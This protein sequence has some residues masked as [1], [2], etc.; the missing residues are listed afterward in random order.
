MRN[1]ASGGG[2]IA[3]SQ[4]KGLV[5]GDP[6][7]DT[8]FKGQLVVQDSAFLGNTATAAGGA[9]EIS[10]VT[11]PARGEAIFDN[12]RVEER[13]GANST[14]YAIGASSVVLLRGRDSGYKWETQSWGQDT[15]LKEIE[16]KKHEDACIACDVFAEGADCKAQG[17][18]LAE[19]KA[20]RGWWR[21]TNRT[22]QFHPC[23]PL[24]PAVVAVL[25]VMYVARRKAWDLR[26]AWMKRAIKVR[27]LFGFVQVIT[28]M[29]V[30]YNL[31]MPSAVA[32]FFRYL[33]FFE[34][35]DI[36]SLAVNFSCLI[37]TNYI[38]KT[39][40]KL[41]LAAFVVGMLL[42]WY[43]IVLYMDLDGS[44]FVTFDEFRRWCKMEW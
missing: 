34:L 11:H 29:T 42:C 27:I 21:A 41:T 6:I 16:R 12:C 36:S 40:V 26:G 20:A 10:V 22:A 39:Y 38:D 30:A 7:D 28:R 31:R 14:T 19:L 5:P 37:D 15:V 2:A 13:P 43:A 25:L 44:G 3:V 17:S 4:L 8:T 1:I 9:D 18:V 24:N 23:D 33:S 32:Q 35:I